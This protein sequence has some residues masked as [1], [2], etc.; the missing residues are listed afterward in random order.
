MQLLI[1]HL[2]LVFS[3][4]ARFTSFFGKKRKQV[5]IIIISKSRIVSGC[6]EETSQCYTQSRSKYV[7]E[8][9][10]IKHLEIL[11]SDSFQEQTLHV[12]K[13]ISFT[14]E[15]DCCLRINIIVIKLQYLQYW[16]RE[17]RENTKPTFHK[18]NNRFR[19]KYSSVSI[20]LSELLGYCFLLL[21]NPMNQWVH[22]TSSNILLL[23]CNLSAS[24]HPNNSKIDFCLLFLHVCLRA[25]TTPM[26]KWLILPLTS[27]F[28]NVIFCFN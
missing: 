9:S 11:V 5:M 28:A 13:I 15:M 17:A 20:C 19:W 1:G 4:V 24:L 8:C 25:D 26:F 22:T 23:K 7:T 27:H 10:Y 16:P 2:T 21:R 12:S 14:F 6:S 3:P 18:Q